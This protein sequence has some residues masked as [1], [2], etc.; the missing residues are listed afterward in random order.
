MFELLFSLSNPTLEFV[1]ASSKFLICVFP[2]TKV[3]YDRERST[4]DR[5]GAD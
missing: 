2:F 1:I 3:S 5:L 4:V